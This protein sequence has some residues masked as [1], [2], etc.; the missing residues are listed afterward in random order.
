MDKNVVREII[1]LSDNDLCDFDITGG[2]IWHLK[3]EVY[4]LIKT[5]RTDRSSGE[6]SWD[7]IVQRESDNKFF[8]WNCW[9]TRNDY[10]MDYGRNNMTEVFEKTIS[11]KIYE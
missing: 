4:K 6:D 10:I 2:S 11:K 5:I 7:T 3:D 1:H 9:E 8:K